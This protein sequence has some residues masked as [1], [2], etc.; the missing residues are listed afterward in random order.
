MKTTVLTIAVALIYATVIAQPKEK[1][2]VVIGKM[3]TRENAL[4]ILNPPDADQGVILP[5]LSTS[6]R[7]SLIPSSP[8][9]NGLTVFDT[10]AK[11]YYFW[12]DGAWVRMHADNGIRTK[13]VSIDPLSFQEVKRS[14]SIKHQNLVVFESENS[15]LTA[16]S[17]DIGQQAMAPVNLPHGATVQEVTVYYMDKDSRNLKIKLLRKSFSGNSEEMIQW[18]SSGSAPIIREQS[19]SS[20]NNQQ[21][22]DLEKYTYRIQ[23]IFDLNGD[24]VNEP[25]EAKQ[26]MYGVKIKYWE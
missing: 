23:V 9:E 1:K 25:D 4:L 18:E 5:Q 13:F 14:N 26:R 3:T 6:Q 16:S 21:V 11:A 22:I 19:F 2:S 10:D 20:F 8:S 24:L 15:Y 17:P 7:T 12:S